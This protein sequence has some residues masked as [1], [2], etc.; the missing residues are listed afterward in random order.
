MEEKL[1]REQKNE[2]LFLN[3]VLMFQTS[4]MQQMGKLKNPFTDKIERD[5]QQ[6]QASID[7]LDMFRE[8]TKGNLTEEEEQV[9]SNTLSELRMGY[10]RVA[11]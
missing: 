11:G 9:L 4:A 8:K 6:A 2:I 10:V 1:S 5:L 7:I 3:L